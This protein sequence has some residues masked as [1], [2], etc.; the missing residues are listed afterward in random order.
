MKSVL[1]I[2]ILI[3]TIHMQIVYAQTPRDVFLDACNDLY[4]QQ[5]KMDSSIARNQCNLNI[6]YMLKSCMNSYMAFAK[7]DP[8]SAKNQCDL[9]LKQISQ[10]IQTSLSTGPLAGHSPGL[11]GPPPP[12]E[13]PIG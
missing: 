12:I 8:D 10:D 9:E 2:I 4:V 3:V 7:M 6:D 1:I 13:S 5:T 11:T